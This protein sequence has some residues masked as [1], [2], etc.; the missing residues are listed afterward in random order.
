[1][2]AVDRQVVQRVVSG[3]QTG[4]D[5]AALDAAIAS[6]VDHGGWCP[7][8][9]LAEDGVIP[10]RYRLVE[11]A[12][13]RYW[14]RT[15]RNVIDSDGTLI[16]HRG[17]LRGGTAFTQRM[18]IKHAKPLYLIDTRQPVAT[19]AIH[20]WIR[21]H[22]IQV[23]NCAGPR[24]SSAPGIGLEARRLL[25]DLLAAHATGSGGE[26]ENHPRAATGAGPKD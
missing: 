19:A 18:A 13:R 1:M 23:L 16:V 26:A 6:G 21:Q 12:S 10:A 2:M 5:R 4:V 7:R 17:P 20:D 22:G 3:G 11:S 9:R 8:G 15:E 14:V 25:V 24:E